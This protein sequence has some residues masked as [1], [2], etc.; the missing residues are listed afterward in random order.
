MEPV[1]S[2]ELSEFH[3]ILFHL[4]LVA[5]LC[6]PGVHR[7]TPFQVLCLYCFEDNCQLQLFLPPPPPGSEG[8]EPKFLLTV[9]CFH[10]LR[11]F[12]ILVSH[13]QAP[14]SFAHFSFNGVI[15]LQHGAQL[16]SFARNRWTESSLLHELLMGTLSF[17]N[18]YPQLLFCVAQIGKYMHLHTYPPTCYLTRSTHEMRNELS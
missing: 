8:S 14:S 15:D 1:S 11:L 16:L 9:A 5:L 13:L 4:P 2:L 17:P 18:S 6:A 3:V 7:T 10:K 12:P